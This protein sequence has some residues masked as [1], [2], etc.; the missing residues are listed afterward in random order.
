[1]NPLLL[2]LAPGVELRLVRV[3]AGE[4]LMGSTDADKKAARHEKP[5]HAVYLDEFLIGEAPVTVGQFGAF[6]RA[7]GYR[8]TADGG[9]YGWNW[10]HPDGPQSDVRA[11]GEHPVTQ[12]NWHGAT[13]FCA[14]ASQASGRVVRL[15]T[16]AEWEKAARG[17]DGRIYPWGSQTDL[18]NRCNYGG[19]VGDTTP[20]GRYSPQGDSPY[21]CVDMAGSVWEWV[22]DWYDEDYYRRSPRENPPGPASGSVRVLRGGSWLLVAYYVRAAHRFG[23]IPGSRL[24]GLGFRVVVSCP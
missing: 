12:V 7:T 23:S 11:K 13:A 3:P 6:V 21:G 24:G 16:E 17:T 1:M 14:W 10:Q 9:R 19:K 8:T 20:V 15:P 18:A 2:S 5:P 4:F 22:A